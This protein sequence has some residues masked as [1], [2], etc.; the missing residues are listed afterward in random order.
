MREKFKSGIK[1][2]IS[3][4]INA[5][6]ILSLICILLL[7]FV[8]YNR[9]GIL[10]GNIENIYNRDI[11]Q[12]SKSRNIAEQLAEL[13]LNILKQVAYYEES[14]DTEIGD[15]I[16]EL[17]RTITGYTESLDEEEKINASKLTESLNKYVKEKPKAIIL[18]PV[19]GDEF[20]EKGI[21]LCTYD[22]NIEGLAE[23][24]GEVVKKIAN[25]EK[26]EPVTVSEGKLL[27]K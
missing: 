26:L 23:T 24:V 27:S 10:K 7:S 9:I 11:Q 1:V 25:G 19:V 13:Q 20:M 2:K 12:M 15:C 6:N 16:Y 22:Q 8:G 5:I 14:L 17:N 3:T 4:A 21:L 18:A